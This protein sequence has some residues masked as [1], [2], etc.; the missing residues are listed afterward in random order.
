MVLARPV[1]WRCSR[2]GRYARN[3]L[4]AAGCERVFEELM[5]PQR[6]RSLAACRRLGVRPRVDVWIVARLDRLAR[7]MRELLTTD[8]GR[9]SI[10]SEIPLADRR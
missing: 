7:S 1:G 10:C 6:C 8:I 4:N 3:A 5:K 2:L 9:S